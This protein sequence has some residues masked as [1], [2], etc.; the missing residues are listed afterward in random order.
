MSECTGR[1]FEVRPVIVFPGWFVE[2]T[3]QSLRQIWVLELKAL[4]KFL[5]NEPQR[6][7]TEDVALA[8]D[9]LARFVRRGERDR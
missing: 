2:Q 3:G 6:L 8:S 7:N 9:H 4:P 1:K 5:E